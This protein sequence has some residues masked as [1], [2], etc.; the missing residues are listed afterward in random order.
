[1]RLRNNFIELLHSGEL[2]PELVEWMQL[3]PDDF[4]YIKYQSTKSTT[5]FIRAINSL[6]RDYKIRHY[7]VSSV[8]EKEREK[9]HNQMPFIRYWKM[10][11]NLNKR[12]R[13]YYIHR[14]YFTSII[15]GLLEY[16]GD[17]RLELL[18]FIHQNETK[19]WDAFK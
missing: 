5:T 18:D 7:K 10:L 14:K 3:E 8:E 19:G 4:F 6:I 11:V 9:L 1:M 17:N 12:Y 15:N 13:E 16:E 2:S